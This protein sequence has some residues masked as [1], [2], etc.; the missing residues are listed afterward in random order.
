M[1]SSEPKFIYAS[2]INQSIKIDIAP[3]KVP[4]SEVLPTLAKRK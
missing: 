2:L 4:F 1:K 3:L